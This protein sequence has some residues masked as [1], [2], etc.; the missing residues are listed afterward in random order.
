MN[1]PLI[2]EGIR[3]SLWVPLSFL[4]TSAKKETGIVSFFHKNILMGKVSRLQ[5]VLACLTAHFLQKR[6]RFLLHLQQGVKGRQQQSLLPV[7]VHLPG[8]VHVQLKV[9]H[10]P[11]KH[12]RKGIPLH[13]IPA[14]KSSVVVI[15]GQFLQ[16]PSGLPNALPEPLSICFALPC[17]FCHAEH[18]FMQNSQSLFQIFFF[19]FYILV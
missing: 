14:Q 12:I 1:S 9:I 16:Q 18:I 8:P 19:L 10:L 7:A 3:N 15:V 5:P 17:L 13:L 2:D 6:P 4:L 11:H